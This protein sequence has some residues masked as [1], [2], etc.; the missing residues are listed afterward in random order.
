MKSELTVKYTRK[1]SLLNELATKYNTDKG[2]SKVN[3]RFNSGWMHHHYTDFYE[4]QLGFAREYVKNVFE[5]GIG[6]ADLSKPA[7]M[8]KY[9]TPGAS[10]RMWRDYFPNA[11]IVGADI[12][13]STLFTEERIE[14]VE[15]DQLSNESLTDVFSKLDRKFDLIV[16]DGLHTVEAAASMY[17]VA[18]RYL[19][20]NGIYVIE[21][22]KDMYRQ[23]YLDWVES[24]NIPFELVV[25]P[26]S[27][28]RANLLVL[29]TI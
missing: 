3:S 28:N 4:R 17:S 9:G 10:L 29:W 23:K 2:S 18:K 21:D 8:G 5:C 27:L 14:T 20:D 25:F 1:P 24:E 12:D 22:I 6:T 11:Q 7:N 19:T 16:D 13:A 15:M 26:K